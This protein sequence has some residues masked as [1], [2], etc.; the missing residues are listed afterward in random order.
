MSRAQYLRLAIEAEQR[1]EWILAA[2]F[3]RWAEGA[4]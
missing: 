2:V 1:R 4:L 3:R